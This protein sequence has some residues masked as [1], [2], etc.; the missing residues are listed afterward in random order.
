[1]S[2]AGTAQIEI[3]AGGYEKDMFFERKPEVTLAL[4]ISDEVFVYQKSAVSE[5]IIRQKRAE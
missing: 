4:S 2:Q 5:T 3:Q 1:M